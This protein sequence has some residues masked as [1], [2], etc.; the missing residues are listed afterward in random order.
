MKSWVARLQKDIHRLQNNIQKEG[1]ELLEK[2]R[3]L[4]LKENLE[5][6]KKELEKFVEMK[7][8]KFEPAYSK[9]L[10]ELQKN[11]K[12]A[13]LDLSILEG[14]LLSKAAK[15]KKTI[16]T[17]VKT[18]TQKRKPAAPK[19]TAAAKKPAARTPRKKTTSGTTKT[20]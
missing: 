12:K 6:K 13:G 3:G 14:G 20:S 1:Y 15:A 11:A 7:L 18:S 5:T 9:L 17:K 8:R 16:R 19:T 4:D 10:K 2:I